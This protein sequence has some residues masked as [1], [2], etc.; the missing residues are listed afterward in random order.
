MKTLFN[1]PLSRD[2][3]RQA[4]ENAAQGKP[5]DL[6]QDSVFKA[7]LT[8][9]SEDSREALRLLLSCCT[10][11]PISAVQV[12]NNESLPEYLGGKSIRFDI[13]ATFNDGEMADME[14]QIGQ[15]GDNITARAAFYAAKLLAAQG[16]KGKSYK[17]IKR[18]YQI[19]FLNCKLFPDSQKLPRRYSLME[20]EEHEKLNDLIEIILY[21][22]P[23]LEEKAQEYFSGGGGTKNLSEEEKW[24]IYIRY[25][26]EERAARLIEKLCGEEEGIMRAENVLQKISRD[27]EKWAKATTRLKGIMDYTS[28]MQSSREG[29]RKEGLQEGEVIGSM[30]AAYK[31][32]RNLKAKG[33]SLNFIAETTGLSLQEIEK[34]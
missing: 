31:V 9:N 7:V 8:D 11:R 21:E 1:R 26:R 34:L 25:R 33:L 12:V 3:K 16:K 28:D 27:Y 4:R 10:R 29:G 30:K 6:M 13:C 23:K 19:F 24:C 14:I 5:L 17:E 15:S 20:E 18:V 32:A 2:L 22:M